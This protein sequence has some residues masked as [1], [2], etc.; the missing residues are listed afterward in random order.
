M[1]KGGC[2]F[3]ACQ[4]TADRIMAEFLGVIGE[5]GQSIIKLDAQQ[6]LAVIQTCDGLFVSFHTL[7]T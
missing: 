2:D 4:I 3:F 7:Q 1:G 6:I 5:I